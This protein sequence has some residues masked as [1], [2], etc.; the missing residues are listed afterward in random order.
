MK[1][2]RSADRH[3]DLGPSSKDWQPGSAGRDEDYSPDKDLWA[4]A[5]GDDAESGSQRKRGD[6]QP[7]TGKPGKSWQSHRPDP[8]DEDEKLDEALEETFPASDPPAPAH[9]DVTGWDVE[10]DKGEKP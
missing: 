8:D 3:S 9:P 10:D 7:G 5:H 2:P 4:Q 6:V 1:T